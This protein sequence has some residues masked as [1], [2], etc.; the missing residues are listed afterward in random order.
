M[1][2]SAWSS[3]INVQYIMYNFGWMNQAPVNEDES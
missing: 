1:I 3:V 2:A